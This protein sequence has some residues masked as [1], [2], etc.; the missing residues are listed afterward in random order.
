MKHI[1]TTMPTAKVSRDTKSH[2]IMWL[3][4]QLVEPKRTV[5]LRTVGLPFKGSVDL[6]TKPLC[7]M[8]GNP[9]RL[10]PSTG[11]RCCFSLNQP[12][13]H[14][15]LPRLWQVR[16]IRLYRPVQ[17]SF[18]G[19]KQSFWLLVILRMSPEVNFSYFFAA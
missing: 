5:S 10:Y 15:N 1:R 4:S 19:L 12:Q 14:S 2:L 18:V 8:W 16:L 3:A 9:T 13:T 11:H 6:V 17:P 7:S